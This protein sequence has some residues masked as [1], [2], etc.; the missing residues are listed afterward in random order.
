VGVDPD[1]APADFNNTLTKL[2]SGAHLAARKPAIDAAKATPSADITAAIAETHESP[3]TTHFSVVDAQGNAVS[4]TYT[5]SA[6]FGSK[7]VIPKTGILLGNALGGFS[8]EGPNVVAAGKRMATSMT[9]TIV[10]QN[11]RLVM[12]LGSPGGDTIPNTVAQVMRNLVDWGMTID[13]AVNTTRVHHQFIPDKLRIERQRP[14]PKKVVAELARRGHS[15]EPNGLPQGDA[16]DILIDAAS[17][18]S[19]GFADPREGGTS[20]GVKKSEL[21]KAGK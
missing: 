2:L 20:E 18:I 5:L 21:P 1:F 19:Y 7:V 9:P 8:T 3:E 15:I 10:T 4:C 12:V 14:L 11:G 6:G 16:N 13:D 17:G